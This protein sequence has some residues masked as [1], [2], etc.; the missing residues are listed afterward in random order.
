VVYSQSPNAKTDTQVLPHLIS[1]QHQQPRISP[2]SHASRQASL[3]VDHVHGSRAEQR[4]HTNST[5]LHRSGCSSSAR[6]RGAGGS[7]AGRRLVDACCCRGLTRCEGSVR[8]GSSARE[9]RLALAICRVGDG[10]VAGVQDS[11]VSWLVTSIAMPDM[12][13]LTRQ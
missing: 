13:K 8:D 10:R 9:A 11:V 2:S 3:V 5:S 7:S 6:R 12:F 1:P 4:A